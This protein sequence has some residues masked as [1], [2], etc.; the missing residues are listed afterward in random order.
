M[1]AVVGCS[2]CSALWIL[3]GRQETARCPQCG[4]T[5]QYAKL[6]KFVESEDADHAREVR[7]SMLASRGGHADA[8]AA[9][10][11]FADLESQV[12]T[13]VVDDEQYLEGSGLDSE[14]I[15]A[16]DEPGERSKD[17][18]E[19]VL[20]AVERCEEP[21]AESIAS[22]ATDRGVPVDYVDR[23]L[24]KLVR[25]GELTESGGRYRRL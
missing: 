25:G 2:S 7:A 5:H 20:E 13:P 21:T 16:V 18:R 17:R 19:I 3:E 23:A 10:D 24:E 11:S 22:Y 15:A 1:Y 14:E 9:V 12:E 8:F 4:K 6:K